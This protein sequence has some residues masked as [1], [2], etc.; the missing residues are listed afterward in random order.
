MSCDTLKLMTYCLNH[1]AEEA[2]PACWPRWQRQV[3]GM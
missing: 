3:P 1:H 2:A